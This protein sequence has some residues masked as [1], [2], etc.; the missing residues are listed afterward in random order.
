MLIGLISDIHGRLPESAKDALAGCD[1]ILCAGDV[2]SQRVLWE[3]DTIAPTVA[4]MGNCDRYA[5][6]QA[7]LP[8][9][10]SPKF[11][12]VRFFMTH[13][14]QDIG[15]PADDV[16]VVV[17][18]HTHVPVAEKRDGKLYVNPG[19]TT[20]PRGGSDC[21]CAVMEIED[22]AVLNVRFVTL[23]G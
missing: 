4:V 7:D 8:A 13:R 21:S 19:S 3:L 18:G 16:D 11:D 20:F 12:G 22:G 10:A 14:P 17:Y 15:T 2:E 9:V 1:A 23:K 5:G 6:L